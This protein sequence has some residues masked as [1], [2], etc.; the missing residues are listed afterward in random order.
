VIHHKHKLIFI[1]IARTGGTSIEQALVEKDWGEVDIDTKHLKASQAKDLYSKFWKEYTTFTVV[2]NPFDRF[3]SM[4][5]T[6]WWGKGLDVSFKAW[7]QQ[8]EPHPNEK[9][10]SLFQAEIIDEELDYELRY[11]TLQE[12]FERMLTEKKI[13]LGHDPKKLP[14]VSQTKRRPYQ[15]YYTPALQRGIKT[16]FSADFKRWRYK[17]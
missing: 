13:D 8:L 11:E 12:D 16:V 9:Y 1:H 10:K 15:C 14:R 3:V 17:W 5:E 2:R 4:Y 7:L 6:G